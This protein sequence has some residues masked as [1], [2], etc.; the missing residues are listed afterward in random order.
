[1]TIKLKEGDEGPVE[2]AQGLF[3]RAA[4]QRRAAAQLAPLITQAES[5]LVYVQE[6]QETLSSLHQCVSSLGNPHLKPTR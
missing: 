4:K 1:M 3:K 5:Q 6:V 2:H